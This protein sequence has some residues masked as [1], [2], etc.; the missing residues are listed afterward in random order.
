MLSDLFALKVL[1]SSFVSR[2]FY[3]I[4]MFQLLFVFLGGTTKNLE[5]QRDRKNQNQSFAPAVLLVSIRTRVE[6]EGLK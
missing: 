4:I 2:C 1:F 5:G 6:I 3:F